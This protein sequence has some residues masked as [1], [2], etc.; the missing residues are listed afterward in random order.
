MQIPREFVDQALLAGPTI[1]FRYWTALA[2]RAIASLPPAVGRSLYIELTR[3]I[4]G[5]FSTDRDRRADLIDALAAA[6]T[7]TA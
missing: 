5:S 7:A 2:A 6:V 3:R 4:S 1:D